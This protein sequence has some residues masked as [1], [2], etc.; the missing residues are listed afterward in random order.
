MNVKLFHCGCHFKIYKN[1]GSLYC[2]PES[3]I[4]YVYFNLIKRI[5]PIFLILSL[6][7]VKN[8]EIGVYAHK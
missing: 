2:I 1:I 6:T 3:N 7:P 5:I 8:Y 4:L